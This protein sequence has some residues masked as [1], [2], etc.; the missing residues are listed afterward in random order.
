MNPST[1]TPRRASC[2]SRLWA[3]P[4]PV[5]MPRD[6]RPIHRDDENPVDLLDEHA[7]PHGGLLRAV[8]ASASQV[9]AGGHREQRSSRSTPCDERHTYYLDVVSGQNRIRGRQ[10]PSSGPRRPGLAGGSA[11]P[12]L[13]AP[14]SSSCQN[15]TTSRDPNSK[16][17]HPTIVCALSSCMR[18]L[19]CDRS[20]VSLRTKEGDPSAGCTC[21]WHRHEHAEWR[22]FPV[23]LGH[24]Q[25][26]RR[27]A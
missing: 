27:T 6:F 20:E 3:P 18:H 15:L 17:A 5:M 22:H 10:L 13:G 9:E 11:E 4:V 2:G 25:R 8:V 14:S 1:P 12:N 19:A 7:V 24:V 16:P 23:G 21:E 26:C